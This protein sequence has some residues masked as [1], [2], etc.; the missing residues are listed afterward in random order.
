VAYRSITII[1]IGTLG[2][3]IAESLSNL[4]GVEELIIVDHDIVEKKN[5]RNSIYRQIDVDLFK[6]D[7]LGDILSI[8]RDI[9]V[10]QFPIKFEEGTTKL[11]HSDLVL[12]CRD[13]TY[14]RGSY[15]DARLYISS[16]YLM[17]DCRKNVKY[18]N[19]VE[20]K[21]LEALT[22]DDLRYA[23]TMVAMLLHSNTIASLIDVG[24]VQK[25]ELDYVTRIDSCSY[26]I[27]YDASPGNDKFVNLPAKIIPIL[28]L[29]REYDLNVFVGSKNL[30]LTERII[31]K[32]S[33]KDGNDLIIN[34]ASVTSLQCNFNQYLVSPFKEGGKVYIELIPE[35]GAA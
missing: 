16:R 13:Y 31:P 11:P 12:D 32:A 24:S 15:L 26:D 34:L 25:Y 7:A 33:L 4:D 28:D 23:S 8:N 17:V 20:G 29:N 27:L 19:P 9:N 21:Y 3:F 30:P 18:D 5:L 6:V 1:G 2:G 35:T 22:K 14:D 10:K